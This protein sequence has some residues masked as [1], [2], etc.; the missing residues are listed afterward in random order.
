MDSNWRRVLVYFG[1][2]EDPEPDDRPAAM[3][4]RVVVVLLVPVLSI[5]L[6]DKRGAAIGVVALLVFGAIF[7]PDAADHRATAAWSRRHRVLTY[8]LVPPAVFL[9]LALISSLSLL[10]CAAM[11]ASA[12]LPLLFPAVRGRRGKAAA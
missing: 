12:L 8:L 6:W 2:A 7:L 3:W 5:G 11:A 10:V 1:L 9:W 4:Q